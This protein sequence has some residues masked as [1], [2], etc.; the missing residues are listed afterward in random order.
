MKCNH[1]AREGHEECLVFVLF[2]AFVVKDRR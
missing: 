2:V 1:E